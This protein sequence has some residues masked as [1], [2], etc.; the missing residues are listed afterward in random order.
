MS[1]T[2]G[3]VLAGPQPWCSTSAADTMVVSAMTEPTDRSMPPEMMTKVIPMAV[4]PRKALS[5]K[6]LRKTWSEKKLSNSIDPAPNITQKRAM[7]TVDG[8]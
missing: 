2:R 4:T 1:R 5:M 3:M 8:Q 7:V 6:K